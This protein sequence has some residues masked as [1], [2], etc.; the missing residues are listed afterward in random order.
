MAVEVASA[1]DSGVNGWMDVAQVRLKMGIGLLGLC[2]AL[3]L[4]AV[5]LFFKIRVCTSIK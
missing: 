4:E 3:V 2:S 5:M 1:G